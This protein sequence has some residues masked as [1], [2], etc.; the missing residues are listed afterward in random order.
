MHSLLY[1]VS[2]EREA[3]RRQGLQP[4]NH[5][6]G[7]LEHL[8]ELQ[9]KQAEKAHRPATAEPFKMSRFKNVESEVR[10]TLS[11]WN[12]D[13]DENGQGTRPSTAPRPSTARSFTRKGDGL[14]KREGWVEEAKAKAA[15]ARRDQ[16]ISKP[17]VPTRSQ[18]EV[19]SRNRDEG[20]NYVHKNA[21][22]AIKGC[23]TGQAS[24]APSRNQSIDRSLP[25]I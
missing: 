7:N 4:K 11:V 3:L 8:R 18:W 14:V 20:I 25:P 22:A 10:K 1:P 9:R 24:G 16:T 13:H 21:I 12:L 17:P 5:H 23:S 6:R 2:N 15:E 19:M